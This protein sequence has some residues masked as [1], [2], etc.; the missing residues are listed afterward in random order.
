[1]NYQ[2]IKLDKSM[3]QK[4]TPFSAQLEALD[5]TSNYSGTEL[6]KL[7]AFGRQL[8]RFDIKVSGPAS[9][10]I[11]KF[12]ST[13]DSAAL[14]P[15][16]VGRAVLQGADE[17]DTINRII[18]SKTVINSMDYRSITTDTGHDT[19]AADVSE[20]AQIPETVIRLKDQ[21]VPLKKYGRMLVS[22][23]E[24]IKFQRI[25]LFSVLLRQIGANITKKHLA[26]AVDVLI[27]GD[28]PGDANNNKAESIQTAASGKLAYDDLLSLWAKFEDFALNTMIVSPDM[29]QKM[30]TL[31]ELRDP[32]AGL[33]FSGSGAIGTPLG[34]QVIRSNAVPAGTIIGLDRAF[35]LEMVCAGEIAVDYDK[36]IN[37]QLER[38]AVTSIAGFAKIFP[39]AV[40]VLR[41]KP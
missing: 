39:E 15:E 2:Q 13:A 41:L 7:D 14:F 10:S 18:A 40:K 23:Y 35:A 17:T 36:L 31:A 11:S 20:G 34:A 21:L 19:A 24:A 32:V 4:G 30:L 3:Y 12:F 33:N 22:S 27:N 37:T 16:Y 28:A 1:M 25:D 8:K 6:G 26:C 38:A 9:D 5:P 29:M